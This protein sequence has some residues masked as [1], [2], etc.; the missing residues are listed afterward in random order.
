MMARPI[1][2]D[3]VKYSVDRNTAE[4]VADHS[5]S[6]PARPGRPQV[7]ALFAGDDAQ[8]DWAPDWRVI[9]TLGMSTLLLAYRHRRSQRAAGDP[10]FEDLA[11]SP[12][13]ALQIWR[14]PARRPA[15]RNRQ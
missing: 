14:R 11:V 13:T 9:Q 2:H 8:V 7:L 3:R 6:F 4:V 12:R 15:R 1:A 5:G 10:Q